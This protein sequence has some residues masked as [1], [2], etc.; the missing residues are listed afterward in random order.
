M[1]RVTFYQNS[2]HEYIGFTVEGHAGYADEGEDIICAAISA[3][4]TNAINS[5]E[6]FTEDDFTVDADENSA[7]I[8]F[9]I[10]GTHSKEADLL[11]KSLSLGLQ[12]IEDDETNSAFIDIIFEEVLNHVTDE[13]S[14]FR[15]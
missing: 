5:I 8:K 4:V 11:L 6:A 9:S 10:D 1:T 14:I 13:P 3:L 2:N 15:S 7:C 12:G